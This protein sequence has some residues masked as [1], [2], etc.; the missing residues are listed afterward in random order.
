MLATTGVKHTLGQTRKAQ[1]IVR[2]INRVLF[3]IPKI[4]MRDATI[5]HIYQHRPI[6]MRNKHTTQEDSKSG[7]V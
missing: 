2:T 1:K 5:V 6:A 4:W 7:Q 3:T